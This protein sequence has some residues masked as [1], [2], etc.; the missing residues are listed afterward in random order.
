V[1]RR[2]EQDS[3]YPEPIYRLHAPTQGAHY[4]SV[5]VN[6][7]RKIIQKSDPLHE[8]VLVRCTAWSHVRE[9]MALALSV[10]DCLHCSSGGSVT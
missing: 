10:R 7:E 1:L 3:R 4:Y 5:A 2:R 6:H 8:P 9:P